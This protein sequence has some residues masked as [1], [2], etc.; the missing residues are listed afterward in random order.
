L[1]IVVGQAAPKFELQAVNAD[2]SL[3]KLTDL[4]GHWVVIYFYP[5]DMTSGCTNEAKDFQAHLEAF[6]RHGAIVLGISRD[7]LASH[8]KF[9]TQQGLMFPLLSD[10][11][12]KVCE[13]Y[14]VYKE[15]KMYGRTYMGI[16]RTT[17]L[18]DPA[19][20]VAKVYPKVKV[21]GHVDQVL[22]DLLHYN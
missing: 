21:N 9:I 5:K 1:D 7:S 20:N 16:E 14:G 3:I 22:N 18:I 11:E 12:G 4:R 6:S 19:G 15:K 13:A 8:E 17:F 10:E 2:H